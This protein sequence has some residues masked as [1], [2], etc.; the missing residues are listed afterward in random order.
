MGTIGGIAVILMLLGHRALEGY[1]DETPPEGSPRASTDGTRTVTGAVRWADGTPAAGAKV[2]LEWERTGASKGSSASVTGPDGTFGGL[3]PPRDIGFRAFG[4]VGPAVSESSVRNAPSSGADAVD[5]KIDLTLPDRFTLAGLLRN[6]TDRAGVAGATLEIAGVRATTG[7][8]GEFKLPD[9]PASSLRNGAPT[10]RIR[11]EGYR[12]LT[13]P[14]PMDLEP[15][16]YGDLTI[17]L[18]RV[19]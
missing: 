11:A 8:D 19:R 15:P 18:E 12:D 2:S 7:K 16:A 6:S 3:R 5:P 1:L 9:V 4:Q 17:L 13:W 10:V 14:L